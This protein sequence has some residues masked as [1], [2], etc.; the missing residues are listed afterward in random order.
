MSWEPSVMSYLLTKGCFTTTDKPG[1][2][3]TN[4]FCKNKRGKVYHIMVPESDEDEDKISLKEITLMLKKETWFGGGNLSLCSEPDLEQILNGKSGT[5]SPLNLLMYKSESKMNLIYFLPKDKDESESKIC[6]HFDNN[7][8]KFT[9]L[10]FKEI[11]EIL[12]ENS[13]NYNHHTIRF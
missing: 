5:L 6:M 9:D 12:T 3:Y 10:T 1:I 13:I 7:P 4:F 2:R 11:N 8:E